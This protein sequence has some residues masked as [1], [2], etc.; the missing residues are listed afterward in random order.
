MERGKTSSSIAGT[1]ERGGIHPSCLFLRA[2]EVPFGV[3]V[4][5]SLG[6]PVLAGW[7]IM[8]SLTLLWSYD[9]SL[10]RTIVKLRI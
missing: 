2:T 6:Q 5:A 7:V 9:Q 3:K 8:V 1:P 10:I 4:A